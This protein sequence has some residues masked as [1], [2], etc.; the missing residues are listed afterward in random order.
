[1]YHLPPNG[2]TAALRK[3]CSTEVTTEDERAPI[4]APDLILQ[5][6]SINNQP[7]GQGVVYGWGSRG[8]SGS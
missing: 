3:I 6:R 1:M 5:T 4:I 2:N 7:E 8:K